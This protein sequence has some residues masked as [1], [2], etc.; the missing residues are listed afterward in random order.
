MTTETWY[1]RDGT[2]L[3][4]LPSEPDDVLLYLERGLLRD[5]PLEPSTVP[6]PLHPQ[7]PSDPL[8]HAI[9]LFMNDRETWEGTATELKQELD[10]LAEGAQEIDTADRRWPADAARLSIALVERSAEMAAEGIAVSRGYKGHERV[11]RL[12]RRY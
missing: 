7:T 2:R 3:D 1:T 5:K 11:V 6:L 12:Y 4:D 10:T 8:V 9:S